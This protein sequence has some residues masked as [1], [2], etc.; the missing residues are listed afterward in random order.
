MRERTEKSRCSAV[1]T[2]KKKNVSLKKLERTQWIRGERPE[3]VVYDPKTGWKV[4]E[5]FR[6][7]EHACFLCFLW[8][9]KKSC[10][11]TVNWISSYVCIQYFLYQFRKRCVPKLD[12]L[13]KKL[14]G[15]TENFHFFFVKRANPRIRRSLPSCKKC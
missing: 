8:H 3:G 15:G 9:S 5:Y 4:L 1:K 14:P 11:Y 6:L 10:I 7:N 12:Q 2:T 13:K